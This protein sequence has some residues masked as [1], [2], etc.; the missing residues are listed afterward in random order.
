MTGHKRW[1]AAV[2]ALATGVRMGGCTV[3]VMVN[4]RE[5]LGRRE[6]ERLPS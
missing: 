1:Y 6:K 3:A 4:H 5:A 2:L